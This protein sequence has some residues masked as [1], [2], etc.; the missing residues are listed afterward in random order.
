MSNTSTYFKHCFKTL[1]NETNVCTKCKETA[2]N[3]ILFDL[4]DTVRINSHSQPI[5]LP[6]VSIL[7][8]LS[9]WS[10]I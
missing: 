1:S 9:E 8:C 4:K 2:I 6:F 5:E 7:K 3:K 10:K